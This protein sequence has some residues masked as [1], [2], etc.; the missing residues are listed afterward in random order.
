MKIHTRK[1][2]IA[3]LVAILV[4]SI[5][6]SVSASLLNITLKQYQLSGISETSE[7]AF[8][9]ANA[10]I[11]CLYYHDYKTGFTIGSAGPS[12]QCFGLAPTAPAYTSLSDGGEWEFEFGW[13]DDG[14]N[15]Y[16]TSVR[17]F[18][19]NSDTNPVD[20]SVA[21]I[22]HD[23]QTGFICTVLVSKG[24]NNSCGSSPTDLRTVE[25]EI[26]FNY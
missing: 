10:G 17:M 23:C 25:R 13:S 8:V 15:N 18:K 9:A 6:L 2:G 22:N 24:Y 4:V 21:G 14:S 12:I 5:L 19:F 1:D 16:C 20:M 11:E 7:L 3:L 26:I